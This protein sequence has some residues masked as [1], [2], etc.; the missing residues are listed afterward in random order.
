[1]GMAKRGAHAC[2]VLF[3][4]LSRHLGGG[5]EVGGGHGRGE[6]HPVAK[7]VLK[8][9]ALDKRVHLHLFLWRNQVRVPAPARQN[10]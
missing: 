7:V 3:S 1:M 2:R 10:H 6:R 5:K 4:S 8:V 9:E